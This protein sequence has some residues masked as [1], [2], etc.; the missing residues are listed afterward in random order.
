[1]NSPESVELLIFDL[2][3]TIFQTTKPVYESVR[4]AFNGLGLPFDISEKEMEKY[5]GTASGEFYEALTPENGSVTVEELRDRIHSE[6]QTV[7]RETAEAFPGVKETLRTL[8]KRGYKLALHSN[9][10]TEYF[11]T[12]IDALDIGDLFDYAEC[13]TENNLTKPDLIRKIKEKFNS[14]ASYK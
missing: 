8:R 7:F 3:G 11:E 12:A 10:S 1:M 4:R 14:S 9:S 13:V 5:F 6:H 2:D